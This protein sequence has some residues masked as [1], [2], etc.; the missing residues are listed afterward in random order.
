MGRL[1][2]VEFAIA[3]ESSSARASEES[4]D[5]SDLEISSGLKA[6]LVSAAEMYS[7]TEMREHLSEL[8]RLNPKS[9]P[10][11]EYLRRLTKA[12]EMDAIVSLVEEM[13]VC[14]KV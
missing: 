3:E 13:V 8:E 12:G 7:T 1:L 4:L 5:L 9:G 14:A 10:E 11:V 2:G 6:K